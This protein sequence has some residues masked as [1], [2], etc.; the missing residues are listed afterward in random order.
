MANTR[1]YSKTLVFSFDGTGNEPGNAGEFTEDESISNILKLHVL[2]GGGIGRDHT[3]T[4]TP[5]RD[6]Q[7]TYYYNG[8]GTHDDGWQIPLFGSLISFMLKNVNKVFA[9][10]FGDVD[11]ILDEA[12]LNFESG[13]HAGDR[14]VLFGFS[15]GAALARKFADIILKKYEDCH[16]SFLG[17]FDTVAAMDGIHRKGEP[18][19]KI[20]DGTL[21]SRIDRAVHLLSLDEN[22]IPFVPTLI[23]QDAHSPRRILEVWFSGVHSD[24]GGGYWFDGL[25]DVTLKFMIEQCKKALGGDI[26]IAAGDSESVRDLLNAQWGAAKVDDLEILEVDDIAIHPLIGGTMHTHTD[27]LDKVV[28]QE[29][30]AVHIHVSDNNLPDQNETDL[31]ILHESV[32]KRFD[33]IAGYRPAALRGVT[34]RL[35]FRDGEL[36]R[37]IQGISGL[38][39][40]PLPSD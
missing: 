32:K 40:Y 27:F 1:T 34:F 13:F 25:S 3:K 12:L 5:D 30:R 28:D 22:R 36:S 6:P 20:E 35:L 15:R 23:V 19:E 11:K 18:I 16:V 2:M 8:I 33:K 26:S 21:H 38:R 39:E 37:P 17:V 10:S 24:V 14:I 31:P 4:V 7:E 9:P 29:P